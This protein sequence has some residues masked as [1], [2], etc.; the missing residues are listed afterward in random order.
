MDDCLPLHTWNLNLHLTEYS[1]S[2]KVIVAILQGMPIVVAMKLVI[3]VPNHTYYLFL[4]LSGN[5][6]I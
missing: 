6:K 5:C 3:Q 1:R 2:H 4:S